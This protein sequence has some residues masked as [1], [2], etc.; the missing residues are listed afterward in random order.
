MEERVKEIIRNELYSAFSD[1]RKPDSIESCSCCHEEEDKK[2]MLNNEPRNIPL[3]LI[4]S[5]EISWLS[6]FGSE[7]DIHYFAPCMLD[8]ILSGGYSDPEYIYELLVKSGL[9]EWPKNQQNA[10][11][12]AYIAICKQNA[13][14]VPDAI[15]SI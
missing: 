8:A 2:M 14:K 4:E 10:V 7:K 15:K 5:L 12:R 11:K 9:Y 1:V 6:T 3:S 13:L